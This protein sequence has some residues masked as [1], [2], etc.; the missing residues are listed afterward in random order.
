MT[1]PL[2]RFLKLLAVF[3]ALGSFTLPVPTAMAGS[4]LV[5][6]VHVVDVRNGTVLENH[7]VRIDG[8]S[9]TAVLP[10]SEVTEAADVTLID[11]AGGY[12]VPGLMDMHVHLQVREH[13]TL[14]LLRGVTTVRNMWGN[15]ETLAWKAAVEEGSLPGARIVTAGALVDGEPPI[16][17]GSVVMTDPAAADRFVRR[18]QRAGYDFV[19][20]YSRLEPPVFEALLAAGSESGLEISGHVPQD[21]DLLGAIEGG[22]RTSEH[23][24]GVLHAVAADR[25]LANPSLSPF[26]DRA[27]ELVLKLDSG[28]VPVEGFIDAGRVEAVAQAAR[29]SGHWFVPTTRVMRNFTSNPVPYIDGMERFMGSMEKGMLPL[30]KAGTIGQVFFG[31]TAVHMAGED[32]HQQL[33]RQA[34]RM[35]HEAG[36][37]MLVGTD[38]FMSAAGTVAIDEMASLHAIGIPRD[39]VMRM[40]TL[41]PARYLGEE[42]RLGEIRAGAIA[43]LVLLPGNPLDDLSELYSPLGVMKAGEWYDRDRIDA[44]LDELAATFASMPAPEAG[45]IVDG[46]H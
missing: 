33:R 46:G 12:L 36:A 4:V 5:T 37:P 3:G 16:W 19:K 18:Q 28:E 6:N 23:L 1:K 22:M 42:G 32:K 43:D 29:K 30:I 34:I 25:S 8:E 31:L 10:I 20:T 41:E 27:K 2:L 11:G 17:E 15:P 13:A 14:N 24:I 39:A 35:L 7:A 9:I 21:V 38:S 26:D 40:A 45:E 44:M